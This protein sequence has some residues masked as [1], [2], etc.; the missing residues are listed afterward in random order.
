MIDFH[1]HIL[2]NIDDGSRSVQES[3]ELLKM[4][5]EQGAET[6][7]ATP[8]FFADRE[9]VDEF[10]RRRQVS[11]DTL[12]SELPQGMP[13]IVLGAEVKYY[14][15]ISHLE[16]LKKLCIGN[17]KLLLL[18][19]SMSKWTEYTVRELI[20]LSNSKGLMP[21]LAH[22]ERYMDFQDSDVW[23]RLL[24]NGVLMQVNATF[25][26]QLRTRRKAFSLLKNNSIHFLGSDCHRVLTRP[27]YIGEAVRIIE[28]KMGK[29][30]VA[31][32]TEFAGAMLV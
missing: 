7:A 15:G 17:S 29:E 21:V 14:S 23:S 9:S 10:L 5:S 6:V 3:V 25:F 22:I 8:H 26:T 2:P 27:P 18:E 12:C 11:Y 4:L 32:M 30:F 19:M 28:K 1:S 24:D 16:D 31:L 13:E 20:E